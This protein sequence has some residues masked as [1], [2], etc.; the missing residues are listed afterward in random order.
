M[1][2]KY[3]LTLAICIALTGMLSAQADQPAKRRLRVSSGVAEGMKIHD[4]PPMYPQEAQAKRMQGDVILGAAIDEKGNLTT[5]KLLQGDA[6]PA[7]AAIEAVQQWKYKPYLLNGDP[8]EVKT[9][10]KIQFYMR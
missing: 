7:K 8:V 4:V 6:I 3:F 5:L 1:R 2:I 9:T 10:I